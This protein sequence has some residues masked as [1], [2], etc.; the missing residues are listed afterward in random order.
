MIQSLFTDAWI[1]KTIPSTIMVRSSCRH[2]AKARQ[3]VC[4]LQQRKCALLLFAQVDDSYN[5]TTMDDAGALV[6]SEEDSTF[7]SGSVDALQ[8]QQPLST[9]A[10]NSAIVP[11]QVVI[12]SQIVTWIERNLLLGLEATPETLAIVTI[13]FVEG[14]LGLARLAQSF[15]LKDELSLGPAEL[16]ALTGLFV[17]PWTIKPLYGFLSDGFPLFGY[18]RKSYLI[19]AGL[20]GTLSYGILS[21]DAVWAGLPPSTAT[22][23]TIA[24]LLVSSACIAFSDVVA[25]GI[26]VTRTR[27][28]SVAASASASSSSSTNSLDGADPLP[29]EVA[30]AT[31]GSAT[32]GTLQSLCWGASA[33]GG[34]LSAYFSGSL[35]EIMSVRSIFGITAVLPFMVALIAWNMDEKPVASANALDEDNNNVVVLDGIRAQVQQL[36]EALRQPAIYKPAL[37]IFLF[38]STPNSGSAF[39]FFLTND[40]LLGPEFLG[41]VRLLEAGA[42]LLGVW[43]YNQYFKTLKIKDVL[44]WSTLASFPLGMLPVLLITHVNRDLGIPD[45]YLI[46]GD[47]VALAIL[48]TIAFMPTL[49]LAA[50]LCPPGVEAVLFATLM[51]IFNGASAVGTE[52]GALLT[53][54]AG[55]TESNFDNL[56]WLTVFCNVSSL[57]PLVLIGWLDGVGD[58]SEAEDDDDAI[59]DE[60]IS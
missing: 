25:D 9:L 27:E 44:Y 24:A 42:G 43:L 41:R 40:L 37:F 59:K 31:D 47:D 15:L 39:F 5:V 23:Y 1:L 11:Q 55:I 32:A 29:G 7:I 60:V 34:L 49:V 26:V 8:Q 12:K 56:A 48:G 36:W 14:A 2:Q 6:P 3:S 4:R 30:N 58:R 45:S 28:S 17:L 51:S 50:R 57:W 53:K 22:T 10:F 21:V 38:Q 20:L 35:L 16:S 33:I 18:R 54:W 19:A 52:T 13:Y 46:M